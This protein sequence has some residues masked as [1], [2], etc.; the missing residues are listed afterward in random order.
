[1]IRKIAQRSLLLTLLFLGCSSITERGH[2]RV[3]AQKKTDARSEEVV[4]DFVKELETIEGAAA[5]AKMR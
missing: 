2:E 3:A 1:M 4:A 5:A